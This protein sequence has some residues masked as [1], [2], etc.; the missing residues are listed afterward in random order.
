MLNKNWQIEIQIKVMASYFRILSLD[1]EYT[2]PLPP[3][4]PQRNTLTGSPNPAEP[5][6]VVPESCRAHMFSIKLTQ[7]IVKKTVFYGGGGGG[8]GVRKI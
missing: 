5:I 1:L 3:P 6:P 8:W 7:P 2:N 4:L